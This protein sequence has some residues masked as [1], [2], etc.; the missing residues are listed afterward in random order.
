MSTAVKFGY[1]LSLNYDSLIKTAGTA[2]QKKNIKLVLEN[3]LE[4]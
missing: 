2:K 3:I 1:F 4:N